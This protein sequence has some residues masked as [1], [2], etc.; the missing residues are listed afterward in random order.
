M[1]PTLTFSRGKFFFH[2]AMEAHRKVLNISDYWTCLEND[3]YETT[4]LRA[5]A[6][7]RSHSDRVA[8]KLFE[9]AFQELYEIPR[10]RRLPEF[11]DPHQVDGVNW[12]L[13][14]KRSYLAHAPGA[15][16]TCEAIVAAC[17]AQGSGQILFI[18]PPN[19]L[20]NWEREVARFTEMMNIWA[21]VSVVP[22][23]SGK[24]GMLWNS[25]I[26]IC[27][28]S[29]ITKSWVYRELE[30]RPWKLIAVDEASR[31]KDP[32]AER[33]LA[34]YGGRSENR[35]FGGVYHDARHVV[36]MDGSPLLNRPMEL[37][38]PTYALDPQAINCMD[39]DDFGYRY[40]G[41]KLNE[42]GQYTFLHSSNEAELKAKLQANFMHV[43]TENELTHPERRRSMLFM[44]EDVR[45]LEQKNW[46]RRHISSTTFH[47]HF[48]ETDNRGEMAHFRKELGLRKVPWIANYV[49]SRLESKDESILLFAW[50]REVCEALERALGAYDPGLVMGGTKP[51]DR[52]RY[53]HE[54]QRGQRK[55]II[56][57]IAAM[58]RGHNLQRAD[59]IVFG[60]FSWTD[61]L[62]K[63]CEHR[64]ARRG[65]ERDF[66]RSD[67]I[68][69]PDSM[70]EP[71]LRSNFTKQ[72]RVKDII[73]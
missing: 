53:F 25:D 21:P 29:M 15:G 20:I 66:I 69:C 62:N 43:V 5:A 71:I 59:R 52:E 48:S 55:L 11:L 65:N 30:A 42:R 47:G 3:S 56:G 9:R 67:Y 45:T 50:H 26:I 58:G 46:E 38:A 8:K 33:S 14:R 31:F 51:S 37:W 60:E 35:M 16:K 2:N 22:G 72:K 49:K 70:D 1:T 6:V 40:C 28:D 19:L 18:V 10:G 41:P 61:E 36:F 34:F 64:S 39:Q 23:T 17:L 4:S 63:Q 57:N 32:L 24:D 68:V 12:I 54:F 13:S 7:F 27:P 44:S 73:G